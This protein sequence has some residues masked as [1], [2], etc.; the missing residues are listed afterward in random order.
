MD[1]DRFVKAQKQDYDQALSE[2][3]NGKKVTH[4]SW[5]I[6][7][8][9]KNLGSSAMSEFYGIEDLKE[10]KAYLDN[11]YLK[12]N[13]IEISQALLD[14]DNNDPTDILGYPDD[15]KVRSC[16]TLFYYADPN[17]DVF[18]K[19]IGKFYHGELDEQTILLLNPSD[20]RWN[21][22]KYLDRQG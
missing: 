4:W 9:L 3:R 22:V 5:Y 18:K 1:L 13:L 14:L 16:M 21:S 2:I 12:K 7:P 15:L 10:A 8:Q 20:S 11:E 19:V 17:I 6:F